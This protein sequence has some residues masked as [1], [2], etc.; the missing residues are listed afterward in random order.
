VFS[1]RLTLEQPASV[2][3]ISNVLGHT[4]VLKTAEN[5]WHC[6]STVVSLTSLPLRHT[7]L[8]TTTGIFTMT[9]VFVFLQV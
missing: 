5:A 4:D 2:V 6:V 8:P 1:A 9:N 3:P 7:R